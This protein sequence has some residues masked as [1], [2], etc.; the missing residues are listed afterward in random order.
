[1]KR[2]VFEYSR[3]EHYNVILILNE[4]HSITYSNLKCPDNASGSII[5]LFVNEAEMFLVKQIE[6]EIENQYAKIQQ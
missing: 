2:R 4:D 1:M 6:L 3:G 5:E